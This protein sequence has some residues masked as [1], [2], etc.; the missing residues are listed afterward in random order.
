MVAHSTIDLFLENTMS[1]SDMVVVLS[2]SS[3]DR[4]YLVELCI[5]N[6]MF[7]K[8]MNAH[9]HHVNTVPHVRISLTATHVHVSMVM[10]EYSAKQVTQFFSY[11]GYIRILCQTGDTVFFLLWL[12]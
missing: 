4:I 6:Q 5:T 11:Y 10:M 2:Q 7:Q 8:S 3:C 1:K 9:H 12:Y